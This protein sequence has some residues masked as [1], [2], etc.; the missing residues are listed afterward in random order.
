M[1]L[2]LPRRALLSPRIEGCGRGSEPHVTQ[3]NHCTITALAHAP[4]APGHRGWPEHPALPPT[5]LPAPLAGAERG[6]RALH[7]QPQILHFVRPLPRFGSAGASRMAG[8]S[9]PQPERASS[10]ARGAESGGQSLVQPSA[11][12]TLSPLSPTLPE[13]RGITDGRSIL[14]PAQSV[15][16]PRSRGRKV[17]S[18]PRTTLHK[19]C[20]FPAGSHAPGHR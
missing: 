9:C 6:V 15:L 14:L 16:P 3:Y 13:C 8:A 5:L 11:N 7:N 12:I 18:E 19:Y 4:G 1:H 2:P 17:G 10:P 20:T